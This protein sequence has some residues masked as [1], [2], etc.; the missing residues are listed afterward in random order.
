MLVTH[1]AIQQKIYTMLRFGE[2]YTYYVYILLHM[3]LY[4]YLNN[5]NHTKLCVTN[6]IHHPQ[7]C[8]ALS[9]VM[10]LLGHVS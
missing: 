1:Y 4:Y 2:F 8:I 6:D 3:G 9:H 7:H 10:F 5:H